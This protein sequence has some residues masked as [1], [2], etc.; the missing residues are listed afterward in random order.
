MP[1]SG[2]FAVVAHPSTN[3]TQTGLALADTTASIKI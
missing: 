2:N 1:S 3:S